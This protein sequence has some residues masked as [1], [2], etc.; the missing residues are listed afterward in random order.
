[1]QARQHRRAL[2]ILLA[3]GTIM[4]L[5]GLGWSG[6]FLM[7]GAG[8]VIYAE[9]LL[10][11]LGGAVIL[12]AR[13]EHVRLASWMA[14]GGLFVF[15]CV[16]AAVLDV[17][18]EQVPRSTHLFL[19]VLAAGAHH[20]FR[21]EPPWAR[22]GCV[23]LFLLAFVFFA[24]MPQTTPGPYA[25]DDQMRQ[26]GIWVN[27]LTVVISLLAV[28]HLQESDAAAHRALHREL[29]DGLAS[30]RFELFYQP[31]IDAQGQIFGAEALLRW[32][33]P[34][35]GLVAPGEFVQAAEETGFILP[36]GQWVL[37]TACEQLSQWQQQPGMAQLKLSI[38]VSPM[39]LHQP[40]FVQLVLDALERSGVDH[41]R[42]T[43]ELTESMLLHDT[44]GTIAKMHALQEAGVRLSLDDFG[45]GYSSLSYLRQM[46]F[47][48][49]KIDR[50]F[51]AEI[52][53]DTQ[54]SSITRNL[55]QLGQ[56]LG[57][58]VIAEGIEQ[59]E[60][61][62]VLRNQGCGYFQGYLFGR[63][64]SVDD[65]EALVTGTPAPQ[66]A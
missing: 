47:S 26:L 58:D 10:A 31:Q 15:L 16:F 63:P 38:N 18:T 28:L 23:A 64:M 1:M 40:D 42:L 46:P 48:E 6:F 50:A 4:L 24:A 14:F 66:A 27:L 35:R 44:A 49:L 55:L 56:D 39:Q 30:R 20:V 61:H 22:Y 62:T 52:A 21:T 5:L 60:Q 33:H 12:T 34:K 45:T 32:H 13:R 53:R 25:M 43:L 65:F 7:R 29:R 11:C 41:H 57:I 19:L 51:V 59:P 37:A 36:L 2:H 9:V 8:P 3:T 17:Q 54:A